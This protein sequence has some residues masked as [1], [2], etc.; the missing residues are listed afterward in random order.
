MTKKEELKAY[1]DYIGK[2]YTQELEDK[3]LAILGELDRQGHSGSSIGY[4]RGYIKSFI[5]NKVNLKTINNRLK[6][7]AKQNEKL[8]VMVLI[9]IIEII[10]IAEEDKEILQML[11]DKIN[12]YTIAPITLADDKFMLCS[13]ED[14]QSIEC[15]SIFKNIHENK[16]YYLDAIIFY[17]NIDNN[18]VYFTGYA[19][20][21]RTGK[22][23]KSLQYIKDTCRPFIPK[24]FYIEVEE[25]IIWSEKDSDNI[26]EYVIKNTDELEKVYEYYDEK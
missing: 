23:V 10:K 21:K 8:E 17:E 3:W 9:H 5:E 13:D 22:K 26:K 16:P 20:D 24:K 2:E 1:C 14:M 11:V 18:K 25:E 19:L 6:K 12:N 15:C 4:L 7:Y